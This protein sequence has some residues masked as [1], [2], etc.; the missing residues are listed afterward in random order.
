MVARCK[1]ELVFNATV[2]CVRAYTRN[3]SSQSPPPSPPR[4][5]PRPHERNLWP[6]QSHRNVYIYNWLRL[7]RDPNVAVDALFVVLLN[8]F[9]CCCAFFVCVLNECCC[10]RRRTANTTS[11]LFARTLRVVRVWRRMWLCVLFYLSPR[12]LSRNR[13]TLSR[14]VNYIRRCDRRVHVCASS[15]VVFVP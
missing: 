3:V 5:R 2:I 4:P 8:Q 12:S 15:S 9:C 6:T 10:N 13:K 11:I 14:H 1:C 7:I